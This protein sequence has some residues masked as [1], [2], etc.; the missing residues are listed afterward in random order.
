MESAEAEQRTRTAA[1]R[2]DAAELER[3]GARLNMLYEDRL[4]GRIDA[5]T[6]D[7]KAGEI[8]EAQLKI[9][10]KITS[11]EAHALPPMQQAVETMLRTSQ[12]AEEFPDASGAEQGWLLRLVLKEASWKG[13][14]LRMS[15]RE[16][17]EKLRLSN[18]ETATNYKD[19]GA[20][21][22]KFDNWL[23][24]RDSNPDTQIQSLQSYR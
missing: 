20:K 11:A 19:L 15:L 24:G 7:C 14:E 21:E 23:G 16:P 6:Y 17:F 9:Q 10:Q 13:G 12:A 18:S 4:D 2:R 8:R 22:A 1:G 3:L 5:A